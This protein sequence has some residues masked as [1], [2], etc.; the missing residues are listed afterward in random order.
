VPGGRPRDVIART[1]EHGFLLL[2]RGRSVILAVL[3]RDVARELP[4][5]E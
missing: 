1:T 4:R 2:R 3:L 5:E